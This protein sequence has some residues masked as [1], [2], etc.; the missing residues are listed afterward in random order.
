MTPQEIINRYDR[1]NGERKQLDYTYELIERFV[2]PGKGR[3][4]QDGMDLEESIDFRHRELYDMAAPMALNSLAASIHGSL[5][6][7][8]AKW[9]H[10]RFR[11]DKLNDSKEA[12]EWLEECND[13]I[14]ASLQ[15]SN[16][17]SEAN[18]FYQDAAGYGTAIMLHE[19]EPAGIGEWRGHRFKAP[20]CREIYF[21]EDH[22]GRVLA[23]YR[24]RQYTCR[25]IVDWFGP[26]KVPQHIR[27]KAESTDGVAE[28]ET[29]I[30]C[31]YKRKL[32]IDE[33]T[34]DTSKILAAD[35]RP[36][37]SKYVL[38]NSVTQLGETEGYYEMPA[39]VLRWAR[40][41]GSKFGHSPGII[42]LPNVLTLNQLIEM[43]HGA[44]EKTVDPPM[45]SVH[46]GII[47]DLVQQSGGIT[48]VR[49]PDDL[50]PLMPPGAYRIDS[51]WQD[52]EYLVR[53][54]R[55]AFYVD[56]LEL[57]ESPAMTATEVRVRYELMQRLLGPTLGRVQTD[58]LDP[59]INR[60]FY[61]MMRKG[62]LPVM[63][64]IVAQAMQEDRSREV[65][66]EYVGPLAR[67]QKI[68]GVDAAERWTGFIAGVA[69]LN[70]NA[71]DVP[72]WDEMIRD[73]GSILGVP[74]AWIREKQDVER[75]RGERMQKQAQAEQLGT[76]ESVGRVA[77]DLSQAGM[78]EGQ[79]LA[80]VGGD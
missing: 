9:H 36:Y 74:A 26:G 65:D 1:L 78:L 44:T 42:A 18:E 19:E 79:G 23:L 29:I 73:A 60:S 2:M 21:E 51:G 38:Y 48:V 80:A 76:A 11:N 15:D 43:I 3:F 17:N 37:Q 49:R 75:A 57:K 33:R 14:A 70:P 47:G 64:E 69:Q 30:H 77:K 66:I 53:G 31:I 13:G 24:Y 67:S 40:T 56:Q 35:I 52:V 63:P 61:M 32:G 46:R 71:I 28:K 10:L 58:F 72:E 8:V 39:Y 45:K 59:L 27:E 5:T 55:Q 68:Q 4:F 16:F 54:I 12:S 62:S 22:G 34:P 20:M 7:P 25:Q 50:Q 6:S 41:A